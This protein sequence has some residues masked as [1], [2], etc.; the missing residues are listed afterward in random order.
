MAATKITSLTPI[1]TI[2]TAV[3]P[4]PIVDVS[5][6]S[7]SSSGTTKKVTVDQIES[8]IF[9]ATGS[10]AIV[11]DNV[12]ALKALTV[13][14]VDDGQ[15]FLTRGYYTDN[16]GGQGTYVYDS[17]SSTADNGGTVIAPTSGSGRYLLQY[18][19]DLN[20]LQF[21]AYPN[22]TNES[23]TTSAIQAAVTAATSSGK[24]VY[25]P[26]GTYKINDS[27]KIAAFT[28]RWKIY[29]DGKNTS[30]VQS[31]ISGNSQAIFEFVGSE[32]S[33]FSISSLRLTW[34]SSAPISGY[35]ACSFLFS[36]GPGLAVNGVSNFKIESILSEN[37]FRFISNYD[38]SASTT[39]GVTI[40]GGIISDIEIGTFYSSAV[41][42]NNNGSGGF[43]NLNFNKFYVYGYTNT[44]ITNSGVY[45]YSD[46]IFDINAINGINFT[47]IEI[48]NVATNSNIFSLAGGPGSSVVFTN[49]RVE[50]I[51]FRT[52]SS[53][54]IALYDIGCT[55]SSFDYSA[56]YVDA[57]V[58]ARGISNGNS[59]TS[60]GLHKLVIVNFDNQN[61]ATYPTL[62]LGAG[63]SFYVVDGNANTLALSANVPTP[64]G[65]SQY[66][67]LVPR[68]NG[69]GPF[70][71]FSQAGVFNFQPYSS[72][73]KGANYFSISSSGPLS[74]Q[75]VVGAVPG[76]EYIFEIENSGGTLTSITWDSS[77]LNDGTSVPTASGKKR[78][79]RFVYNGVKF[80]QVGSSSENL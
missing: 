48:N 70:V 37:G 46:S 4:L 32:I 9:G 79:T 25:I 3:D 1:S 10:K 17:S 67:A 64:S 31:V 53:A 44:A 58:S 19:G 56:V 12:A 20:V 14:S 27:I 22:N 28:N 60:L 13:A 33:D 68:L 76:C 78:T 40:W 16:D 35:R 34:A 55:V 65:G 6:T 39:S 18:S 59:G 23:T 8:S 51:R 15:L 50:Q 54:I 43:P 69:D 80:V 38:L 11:V 74:I 7:Q 72:Y 2:D 61:N 42:L 30:I 5:D 45:T 77:Y 73:N 36:G 26:F 41:K 71:F 52:S 47:G 29:G 49:C 66:G 57:G 21:G 24:C 75:P 63:A 62:I